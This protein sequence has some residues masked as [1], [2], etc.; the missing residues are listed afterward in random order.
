MTSLPSTF[1]I[2][3]SSNQS[4]G[5]GFCID[6][7]EKGSYLVT[8]AH[9]VEKCGDESLM[10][11]NH[12]A[13]VI[14]IEN[15]SVIDLAL[16]YVEGLTDVTI[17][18]LCENMVL[19]NTLFEVEGFKSHKTDSYKFE[20][21]TG[22][23]KKVSKITSNNQ[24]VNIYEL[25]LDKENNIDK[26]FSGSAIV[27]KDTNKVIAVTTDK[28]RSSY[29]QAYAI[30]IHYLKSISKYQLSYQTCNAITKETTNQ[31]SWLEKK[32]YLIPIIVAIIGGVF[33]IVTEVIKTPDTNTSSIPNEKTFSAKEAKVIDSNVTVK[34]TSPKS[35]T[36]FDKSTLE[37]STIKVYQ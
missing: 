5:T 30:P 20:K 19:P 37:S 2:Q 6:K 9:V 27:L 7:D 12:T 29:H 24:M 32:Q 26:G 35:T 18:E 17:M 14:D 25:N 4:I 13:K 36:D 3:S 16:L 34:Q 15:N 21:L 28:N 1:L 23:I 11:N 22:N 10:V 33:A 8:C 31:T